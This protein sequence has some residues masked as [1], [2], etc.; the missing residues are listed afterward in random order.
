M[1]G[2]SELINHNTSRIRFVRKING[3]PKEDAPIT[4]SVLIVHLAADTLR[5]DQHHALD[6]FRVIL[7]QIV[8]QYL[9]ETVAQDS[10]NIGVVRA[11]IKDKEFENHDANASPT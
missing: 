1:E 2:F 11:P 4:A 9:G 3:K 5:T 10:E 8:L 6:C 7:I